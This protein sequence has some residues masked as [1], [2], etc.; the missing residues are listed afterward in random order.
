MHYLPAN[1]QLTN[2]ALSAKTNPNQEV[3]NLFICNDYQYQDESLEIN[4]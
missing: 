3:H 2:H 1:T 4:R